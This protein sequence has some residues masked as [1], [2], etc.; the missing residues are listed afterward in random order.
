MK[1]IRVIVKPGSKISRCRPTLDQNI[2][3]AQVKSPAKD[4]LANKE[5]IKLLSRHFKVS[6]SKVIILRGLKQKQKLIAI[7]D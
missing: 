4:G 1:K 3:K 6:Q 7:Y 2:Y 5:L